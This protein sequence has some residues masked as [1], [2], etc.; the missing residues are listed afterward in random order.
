MFKTFQIVSSHRN[1][2]PSLL[3]QLQGRAPHLRPP[4]HLIP[5]RADGGQDGRARVRRSGREAAGEGDGDGDEL[6]AGWGEQGSAGG[7][8]VRGGRLGEK[9][10]VPDGRLHQR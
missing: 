4:R 5:L 1:A 8:S 10:Q 6:G 7:G 2:R 9:R 3:C